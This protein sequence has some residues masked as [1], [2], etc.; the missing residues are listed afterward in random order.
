[1]LAILAQSPDQGA[2]VSFA[3]TPPEKTA[4]QA[5]SLSIALSGGTP[6]A[7]WWRKC[8]ADPA[9]AKAELQQVLTHKTLHDLPYLLKAIRN[10]AEQE[11]D[12]NHAGCRIALLFDNFDH[13]PAQLGG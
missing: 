10:K 2:F 12:P 9:K 3:F 4:P 8:D 1:L 13:R 5:D 11:N 7:L 6:V